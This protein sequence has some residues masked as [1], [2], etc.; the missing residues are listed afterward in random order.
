MYNKDNMSCQ[1]MCQL[2][3]NYE[4]NPTN[5]ETES[6]E[7]IAIREFVQNQIIHTFGATHAEYIMNAIVEGFILFNLRKDKYMLNSKDELLQYCKDTS[8]TIQEK[9]YFW[10][11][12]LYS[13]RP[14]FLTYYE[15][16]Y[17]SDCGD[18]DGYGDKDE[19]D[20]DEDEDD[21]QCHTS[22]P[23]SLLY[24]SNIAVLISEELAMFL[25]KSVGTKMSRC[26]VSRE[27]NKYIRENSLEDSDN[28]TKINHDEK[29]RKLLR[30]TNEDE[31]TYFNIAKYMKHHFIEVDVVDKPYNALAAK[32]EASAAKREVSSFVTPTLISNELAEFLGKTVGTKMARTEVSK[33]INAY[34]NAY[35]SLRG[36]RINPDEK[37]SKLLKINK[38][39]ELTYFNL[40]KY[41]KHHFIKTVPVV[42]S[43]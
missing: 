40:Q 23:K 28:R 37:L 31:L 7:R 8:V 5:I 29:L 19:E 38:G 26:D 43:V 11:I 22:P 33:E 25:D 34:I 4:S 18:L 36:S 20:E 24:G 41:M 6:Q 16:Q 13:Q 42:A 32:R 39:D 17:I 12:F 1:T 15:H 21:E 9:L 14:K 27:I 3:K 10:D 35:C 30:L 2:K